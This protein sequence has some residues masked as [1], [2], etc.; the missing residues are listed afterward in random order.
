MDQTIPTVTQVTNDCST[1]VPM[2]KKGPLFYYFRRLFLVVPL[3]IGIWGLS[4]NILISFWAYLLFCLTFDAVIFTALGRKE[5]DL[6]TQ[7]ELTRLGGTTL[8]EMDKFIS[9]TIWARRR[10]ALIFLILN[11]VVFYLSRNPFSFGISL[12][13]AYGL[14]SASQLLYIYSYKLQKFPYPLS[15]NPVDILVPNNFNITVNQASP[16]YMG[17][18]LFN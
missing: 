14:I 13:V 4:F 1:Q 8:A 10:S 7:D 5:S 16:L 6:I 18:N 3:I 2:V 15:D 9:L 12:L 17:K 11:A